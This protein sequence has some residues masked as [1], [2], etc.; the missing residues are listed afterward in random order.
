VTAEFPAAGQV[1][2]YR[3]LRKLQADRGETEGRKKRPPAKIRE[4]AVVAN[5]GRT[6]EA[7]IHRTAGFGTRKRPFEAADT[8]PA[9]G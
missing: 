8:C 1:F 3:Y 6:N 2:D 9:M 4:G 5:A 7:D